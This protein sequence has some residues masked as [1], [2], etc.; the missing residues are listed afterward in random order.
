MEIKRVKIGYSSGN[1]GT[2]TKPAPAS[3]SENFIE[4]SKEE[5][6]ILAQARRCCAL[7]NLANPIEKGLNVCAVA[8][9]IVKYSSESCPILLNSSQHFQY[10]M[11]LNVK[12]HTNSERL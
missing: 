10:S 11:C 8:S 5:T 1:H 2:V 3:S 12:I 6:E 9:Q 4:G 7:A